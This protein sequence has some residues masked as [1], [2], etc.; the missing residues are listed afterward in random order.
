MQ[1]RL[2]TRQNFFPERVVGSQNRL[3][4]AVV[5]FLSL[6]RFNRCADVTLG[7]MV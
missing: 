1:A 2:D 4:R 3:P 5:K 6:E 7:N